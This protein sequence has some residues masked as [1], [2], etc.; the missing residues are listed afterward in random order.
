MHTTIALDEARIAIKSEFQK[1]KM[2]DRSEMARKLCINLKVAYQS[3]MARNAIESEIR[4]SD[5][6]H[7]VKNFNNKKLRIDVKWIE[8]RLKVIFGHPKWPPAAIL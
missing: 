5:V 6:S 7:F 8:I 4:T 3:E 1:S 2:V